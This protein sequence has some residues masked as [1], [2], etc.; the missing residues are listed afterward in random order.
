M[1]GEFVSTLLRMEFIIFA[2]TL[3]IETEPFSDGAVGTAQVRSQ[4]R[5]C[6]WDDLSSSLRAIQSLGNS[7]DSSPY[8]QPESTAQKMG[9]GPRGSSCVESVNHGLC[10]FIKRFYV[11]GKNLGGVRVAKQLCNLSDRMLGRHWPAT[12]MKRAD[13]KFFG[14]ESLRPGLLFAM[15]PCSQTSAS[16]VFVD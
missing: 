10:V 14:L 7:N 11:R 13:R 12:R 8:E 1:Q 2:R 16:T 9:C 5:Y 3:L 6:I 4:G 15:L